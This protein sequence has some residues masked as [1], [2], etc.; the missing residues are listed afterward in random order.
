M[1]VVL[2]SNILLSALISPHAPPHRVYQAWRRGRFEL[3]TATIQID[4]LRRASRYP[5]FRGILQPHRVGHML[6]NLH[7]TTIFDRLPTGY[8]AA[9]PD[10]AWLLALA[11]VARADN[12]VTGDKRSGLL[13]RRRVGTARILTA[14]AFCDVLD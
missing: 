14:A 1:R 11:D 8:E 6:N 9:D 3:I 12:L 7:G 10:D 4:E 2:D 5:K 13:A